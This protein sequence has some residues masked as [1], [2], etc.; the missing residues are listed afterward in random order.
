MAFGKVIYFSN[1]AAYDATQA[2]A[3]I[4]DLIVDP[5]GVNP[6]YMVKGPNSGRTVQPIN[7][8]GVTLTSVSQTITDGAPASGEA[9]LNLTVVQAGTVTP[10]V[11]AV[12][13]VAIQGGIL[14]TANAGAVGTLLAPVLDA[15]QEKSLHVLGVTGAGG[16]LN[17][18]LVGNPG[19]ATTW[20]AVVLAPSPSTVTVTRNL[21]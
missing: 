11:G 15:D 13:L 10:I 19:D 5:A 14:T 1:P 2:V 4:G 12:V 18:E 21:P 17:V 9:T 6:P 3:S 8:S 16:V 7:A 20:R